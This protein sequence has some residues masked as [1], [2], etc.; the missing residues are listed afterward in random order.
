MELR[1]WQK[2]NRWSNTAMAK[3]IGVTHAAIGSI[4]LKRYKPS[5]LLATAIVNFTKG[6]VTLADLGFEES[7]EG[8]CSNHTFS[9]QTELCVKCGQK[10]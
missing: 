7:N 9:A 8:R 3:E 1:G 10:H 6:E 5:L 4:A 2:L